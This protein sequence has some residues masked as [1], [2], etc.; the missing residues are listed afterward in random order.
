MSTIAQGFLVYYDAGAFHVR[1]LLDGTVVAGSDR[2]GEAIQWAVDALKPDGGEVVLGRGEFSVE[3]PVALA[4]HVWLRGG[5]RGTRVSVSPEN[6]QGVA[7]VCEQVQGAEISNLAVTARGNAAASAG[8]VLDD[9]YDCK[10]RDL[11]A[12]GFADYG[13][14]LRHNTFLS[15]V[16]GCTLAGN[17]KANL[18]LEGMKRGR[19]GNFIPNLVTNCIV[20]GGGKGI[21]ASGTTVLNIVGCAVYQTGDTGYHISDVS[22]SV[23][24]S[25][26]R[27]FQI[28]GSAVV[29]EDSHEFNLSSNI[30][31]WHTEHGV[32]VKDSCWGAIC[33]N[34]VIDSGSYN[35][36]GP[37]HQTQFSALPPNLP[38][39]NGIEMLNAHG[40]SVTGNTIFNWGVAPRIAWGVREDAESFNNTITGNNVNYFRD[41]VVLS[42]GRESTVAANVGHGEKP[43]RHGDPAGT[44]VQSFEPELTAQLI[45]EM[46]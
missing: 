23:V 20:Y 26:C 27:T 40:Y 30:F 6:D 9:C 13:V 35:P 12:V 2:A 41:G 3:R 39:Y 1:G 28:T 17:R 25:G 38:L 46:L 8:V 31:C 42:Q 16:R 10:L 22:N 36:G 32:V 21:H 43:H 18:Y 4:N 14:W 11:F 45:A 44:A 29:V 37:D 33:G 15:D 5:G 34:E 19:Y 7:I 24:I